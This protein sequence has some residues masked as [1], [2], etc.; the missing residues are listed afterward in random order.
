MY[1]RNNIIK[2]LSR[3]GIHE[4]K[5]IRNELSFPCPF[6]HCDDDH[7]EREEYHCSINLITGQYHC[8]KCH[9]KG[10]LKT[11]QRHFR[12]KIV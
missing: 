11:L 9:A 10:N 12:E 1:D 6:G 3:Q 8:F 4:Y 7:R 2:L 5:I